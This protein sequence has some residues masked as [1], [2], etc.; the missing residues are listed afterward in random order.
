MIGRKER[1]YEEGDSSEVL[2]QLLFGQAHVGI[3]LAKD[4]LLTVG[5]ENGEESPDEGERD[6]DAVHCH[7]VDLSLP[8]LPS[9]PHI[10]V[11]KG[12]D[13]HVVAVLVKHLRLRERE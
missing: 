13:V 2:Q 7:P 5:E 9:P 1:W 4:V 8:A 3:H 12:T 11:S 6:V 10:A